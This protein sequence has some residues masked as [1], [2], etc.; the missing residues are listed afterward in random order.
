MSVDHGS[1]SS[2]F[3]DKFWWQDTTD[4]SNN[5]AYKQVESQLVKIF[6]IFLLV[7]E[8]KKRLSYECTS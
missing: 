4:T 1:H 5:I 2:N 8:R 7:V 3:R 6:V